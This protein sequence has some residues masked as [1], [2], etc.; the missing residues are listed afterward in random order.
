[1]EIDFNEVYEIYFK[2]VFLFMKSIC[3]DDCLA[4]EITQETF[5]KVL[6]SIDKYNGEVDIHVWLF[7]IAK[8]TYYSH[9]K[10]GK[11][12]ISGEVLEF[13]PASDIS[14]TEKLVNKELALEVHKFIHGMKEPYKEVF[15]LRVFGELPLK[16]IAEIFGKSES[17][18]RVTY[19]RAKLQIQKFMEEQNIE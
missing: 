11:R 4:E 1:M 14:I 10:K 3:K 2:D 18:A 12:N 8:N 6:K 16:R 19:Y 5:F 9:Y 7:T 17:W 13:I 15:T